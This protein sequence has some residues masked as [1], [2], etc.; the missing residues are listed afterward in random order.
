MAIK[1]WYRGG[2]AR[3]PLTAVVPSAP[4]R[5]CTHPHPH[6]RRLRR[7]A[8]VHRNVRSARSTPASPSLKRVQV[9]HRV[10]QSSGKNKLNLLSETTTNTEDLRRDPDGSLEEKAR[11][12]ST[13][14]P[15]G[16]GPRGRGRRKPT[17][18][19]I[20]TLITMNRSFIYRFNTWVSVSPKKGGECGESTAS[21]RWPDSGR[22][23]R[24]V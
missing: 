19:V 22:G 8:C 12:C 10:R 6:V 4:V 24:K 7:A 2:T 23:K 18:Y 16:T 15:N 17:K 3:Q 21:K 20:M 14:P 9:Q 1:E 5:H 11:A 13:E